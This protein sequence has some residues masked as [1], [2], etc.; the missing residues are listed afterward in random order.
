MTASLTTFGEPSLA[1]VKRR[2]SA[3]FIAT[4]TSSGATLRGRGA[5]RR[6]TRALHGRDGQAR[7]VCRVQRG[8]SKERDSLIGRPTERSPSFVLGHRPK[9]TLVDTRGHD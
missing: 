7:T 5:A 2:Q 8:S 9:D 1:D 4:G 6:A 3:A